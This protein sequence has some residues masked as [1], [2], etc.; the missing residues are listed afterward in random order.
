ML[1]RTFTENKNYETS[2]LLCG[3]RNFISKGSRLGD[4]LDQKE[5]ARRRRLVL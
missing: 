2:C 4:W 5:Q 3:A 1:D